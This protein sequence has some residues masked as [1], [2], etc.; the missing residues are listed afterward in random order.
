VPQLYVSPARSKG[1]TTLILINQFRSITAC[2]MPEFSADLF[3]NLGWGWG[4]TLLAF[5]A[6]VAVPAPMIVSFRL[7]RDD[8]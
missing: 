4:G 8:S 5:V 3:A 6:L 1:K 7:S 2:I